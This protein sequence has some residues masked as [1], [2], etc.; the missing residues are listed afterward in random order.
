MKAEEAKL[1]L[2]YDKF[3]ALDTES[4]GFQPNENFSLL[5][6]IGAVK[7]VNGE[8]IDRFDE[9]IN[10]GIKIPKK[11]TELTGITNEM[12]KDKDN[13]IEVLNRFRK[14]CDDDKYIF[15]MH[16]ATHDLKFL[17]YFG[18]K[19]NIEFNDPYIDTQW[20]A[21][22]IL[23]KG[24]W[25]K[26][27]TRVNENYKLATLALFYNIVDKNHHRADN[28]AELTMKVFFKLRQTA[29]K[30]E[31]SLIIKQFW[32][33]PTKKVENKELIIANILSVSP[34]D[35]KK[36]IYVTL[37]RKQ[38]GES[39]FA[40]VYYDFNF[41]CWGIKQSGFPIATFKDLEKTIKKQYQIEDM[42][43]D[44]F[45]ERRYFKMC[46]CALNNY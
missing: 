16:N 22:N 3:I 27:N 42:D 17:N 46:S 34:W 23:S 36:R 40:T 35:K 37:S 20:L 32:R 24:Y 43:F 31:P 2:S 38:D 33:Y 25:Q 21:K 12:V 6:E 10:P 18:E 7:C 5:L 11:I 39:I 1:A 9:L 14:W 15:I 13:Y 30:K 19:C 28:D 26:L 41:N 45:K 29:F 8:I 4:T 44:C